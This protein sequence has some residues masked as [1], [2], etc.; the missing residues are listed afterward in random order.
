MKD[1]L[2]ELEER[3]AE[4]EKTLSEAP[5]T[6]PAL[7][8][9]MAEV[10]RERVERLHAELNRPD[11]RAQA[12]GILRSLIE[13]I[14]LVPENGRLEIEVVGDLAGILALGVNA[15]SPPLVTAGCK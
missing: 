6:A 15:N 10:Y 3:K 12:T 4:L 14:R 13:E 1:E 7:H 11:V 9:A 8:P 2:L 5:P